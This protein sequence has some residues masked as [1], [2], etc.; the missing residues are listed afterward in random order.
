LCRYGQLPNTRAFAQTSVLTG[1]CL[2]GGTSHVMRHIEHFSTGS[3][4]VEGFFEQVHEVLLRSHLIRYANQF[5]N[6]QSAVISNG[7]EMKTAPSRPFCRR[8]HE[9]RPSAQPHRASKHLFRAPQR[10]ATLAAVRSRSASRPTGWHEWHR[11]W[12]AIHRTARPIPLVSP[13]RSRFFLSTLVS[14][15]TTN[16]GAHT[17]SSP[18]VVLTVLVEQFRRAVPV[19]AVENAVH[20]SGTQ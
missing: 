13:D 18:R 17:R 20:S 7:E 5:T 10:C 8:L 12:Q 2:C 6:D 1:A 15:G 9:A 14:M 16:H 4:R 19:V 3:V 11:P